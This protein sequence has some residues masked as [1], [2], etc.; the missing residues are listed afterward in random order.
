MSKFLCRGPDRVGG[1]RYEGGCEQSQQLRLRPLLSKFKKKRH[2]ETWRKKST[3][4]PPT[5]PTLELPLRLASGR[6]GRLY[7]DMWNFQPNK[8]EIGCKF[9]MHIDCEKRNCTRQFSWKVSAACRWAKQFFGQSYLF[10]KW[11]HWTLNCGCQDAVQRCE[12]VKG[13]NRR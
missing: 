7:L 10:S 9:S 4:E 8:T 11:L 13:D 2:R 12:E 5:V 6:T 1:G 3:G